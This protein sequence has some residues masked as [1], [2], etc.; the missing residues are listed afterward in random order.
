NL[1]FAD[2]ATS[3]IEDAVE[4]VMTETAEAAAG[5]PQQK[6]DAA[7]QAA[8]DAGKTRGTDGLKPGQ[9]LS[10]PFD[11]PPASEYSAARWPAH[12]SGDRLSAANFQGKP[13]PKALGSETYLSDKPDTKGRLVVVDF[14]ATWCPPCRRAMPKLDVLQAQHPQDL[15]I[16][17]I[18]DEPRQ[19]VE[20]YLRTNPHDYT[21]AVDQKRTV[22]TPLQIRGIPH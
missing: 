13:L 16:I 6:R 12:N 8:R 19:K 7:E 5:V 1:R 17:G 3:A 20:G 18:S 14:W 2:V 15:V 11:L 21:Q 4:L 10:V 22:S 9:L